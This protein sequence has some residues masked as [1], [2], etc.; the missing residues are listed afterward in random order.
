MAENDIV[1][2]STS[3]AIS[4]LSSIG[5]E[6]RLPHFSGAHLLTLRHSNKND[7]C[8]DQHSTGFDKY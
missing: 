8:S 4:M 7:I 6:S 5:R 3:R 1:L 2:D